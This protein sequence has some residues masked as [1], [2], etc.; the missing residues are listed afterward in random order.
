MKPRMEARRHERCSEAMLHDFAL[1]TT[2]LPIL[3]LTLRA[4]LLVS[5]VYWCM[6]SVALTFPGV[7]ML[8]ASIVYLDSMLMR[9]HTDMASGHLCLC[10][11]A[12][13]TQQSARQCSDG[14]ML[15]MMIIDL[16]WSTLVSADMVG[17]IIG[18][19]VH[20]SPQSK[21]LL[22]CAFASAHVLVGCS[23]I[24]FF[25]MLMRA[26]LFYV[27]CAIVI[28]C[29]PFVPLAHSGSERSA[30]SVLHLCAPVL[31]VHLYPTIASVLVVVGSHARLIYSSIHRRKQESGKA[32]PASDTRGVSSRVGKSSEYSQYSEYSEL[33]V[34]LAAAKRAHGIP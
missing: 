4:A 16:V 30:C 9:S 11:L 29:A 17:S 7:I 14:G 12:V 31:F 25:E 3:G 1:V 8:T 10:A 28:L 21:A 22:A 19:R 15:A 34:K 6:Y 18:V 13:L 27:L 23:S 20:L 26:V 5:F 32:E 2:Y 33:A 24:A